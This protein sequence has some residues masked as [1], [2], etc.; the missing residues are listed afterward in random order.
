MSSLSRIKRPPNG[1]MI[2]LAAFEHYL[3]QVI[4]VSL[5]N[6]RPFSER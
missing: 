4:D 5:R 3:A 1:D 2:A 6:S